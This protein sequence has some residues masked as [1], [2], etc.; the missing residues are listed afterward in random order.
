MNK[1]AAIYKKQNNVRDY[2][3]WLQKMMTTHDAAGTQKTERSLYLATFASNYQAQKD[4]QRFSGIRLNLPLKTSLAR[5]K[6]ALSKAVKSYEK[7]IGYGV[8]E[9]VTQAKFYLGE[10]YVRLSSDLLESERP[11]GLD[12]LAQDQYTILLEEQTY[13]FEDKAI[14][15]HKSNIVLVK[16]NLY[17]EWVKRSYASLAKLVP[18]QFDKPENREAIRE[19]Y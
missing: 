8:A 11:K 16:D 9:F 17:D 15:L 1:L 3:Y 10:I 19:L 12:A 7:V 5:K 18:G 14:E 6:Q 13:P 2:E 4:Y